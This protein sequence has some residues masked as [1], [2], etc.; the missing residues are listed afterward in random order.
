VKQERQRI[1]ER[2][3]SDRGVDDT[4]AADDEF[5]SLD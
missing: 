5:S 3:G 1:D 4:S 2:R